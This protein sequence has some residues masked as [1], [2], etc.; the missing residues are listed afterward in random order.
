MHRAETGQPNRHRGEG[1]LG[2][3]WLTHGPGPVAGAAWQGAR[4]RAE[5][6]QAEAALGLGARGRMRGRCCWALARCTGPEARPTRRVNGVERGSGSRSMAAMAHREL[7]RRGRQEPRRRCRILGRAAPGLLPGV[8]WRPLRSG[9][10][11]GSEGRRGRHPASSTVAG[12]GQGTRRRAASAGGRRRDG[13]WRRKG[14]P[15]GADLVS[16][17]LGRRR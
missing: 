1:A 7:R 3:G 9:T 14:G 13:V 8:G 6:G 10:A 15:G 12:A 2:C 17:W 11:V 5:R 16:P 4:W